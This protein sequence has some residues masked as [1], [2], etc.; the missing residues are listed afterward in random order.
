MMMSEGKLLLLLLLLQ[1]AGLQYL[2][3]Q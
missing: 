2:Q 1:V 3:V